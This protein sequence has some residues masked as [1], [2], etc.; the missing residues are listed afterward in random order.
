MRTDQT[1]HV[2]ADDPNVRGYGLGWTL[3]EFDENN[4]ANVF[5]HG[6][7]GGT[8]QWADMEAQLG[9]VLL[10]N[11]R[12]GAQSHR[13]AWKDVIDIARQTWE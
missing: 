3:E 4:V 5:Q 13:D 2:G 7:T 6:G 10:T 12:A 1:A 9:I 8:L 11:L